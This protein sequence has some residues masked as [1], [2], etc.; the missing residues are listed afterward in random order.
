MV[1]SLPSVWTEPAKEFVGMEAHIFG[2]PVLIVPK[3]LELTVI[4]ITH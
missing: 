2:C 4:R 1:L 3:G